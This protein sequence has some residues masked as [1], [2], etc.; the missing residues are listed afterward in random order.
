MQ[1]AV[2][3]PTLMLLLNCARTEQIS[4]Y[5]L[6]SDFADDLAHSMTPLAPQ[7]HLSG[8]AVSN[9]FQG[10]PYQQCAQVL[11][12]HAVHHGHENRKVTP[13]L[14]RPIHDQITNQSA[15]SPSSQSPTCAAKPYMCCG[16][17]HVLQ[18]LYGTATNK[19]GSNAVKADA[20][21]S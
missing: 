11:S 9:C 18:N 14:I 17:L 16:T 19:N 4:I 10:N 21:A 5:S 1:L 13:S 12:M 15:A 3:T 8:H 7:Q 6:K 20:I 2:T